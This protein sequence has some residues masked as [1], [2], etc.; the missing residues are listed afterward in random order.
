MASYFKSYFMHSIDTSLSDGKKYKLNSV[1]VNDRYVKKSSLNK[2]EIRTW[3]IVLMSTKNP[4]GHEK[5]LSDY[6]KIKIEELGLY[7]PEY[8]KLSSN[9]RKIAIYNEY[10]DFLASDK[11]LD[12]NDLSI[13]TILLGGSSISDSDGIVRL[14]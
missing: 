1:Y 8:Y 3:L 9:D 2:D 10:L 13:L 11:P 14:L 12:I 5:R 7:K 6:L 4:F